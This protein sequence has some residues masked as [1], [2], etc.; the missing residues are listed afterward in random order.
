KGARPGRGASKIVLLVGAGTVLALIVA[1]GVGAKF[2]TPYGLFGQY[3]FERFLP[4]AG[5]PQQIEEALKKSRELYVLDTIREGRNALKLL[6]EARNVAGVNRRLLVESAAYEALYRQRFGDKK[7]GTD[8]RLPVMMQRIEERAGD[9]PHLE[10]ARAAEALARGEKDQ[11]QKAAKLA[12][13]GTL[14]G[15]LIQGEAQLALGQRK[16][17]RDAFI[18]ARGKGGKASAEWGIARTW[19]GTGNREE[20]E[21]AIET[22][23]KL[24]PY[25]S[26]ARVEKARLLM[27]EQ[28][29]EAISLLHEVL[30]RKKVGKLFLRSSGTAKSDA[31]TLLGLYHQS[32]RDHAT[33]R[34]AFLKAHETDGYN[35]EAYVYGGRLHMLDSNYEEAL[36]R[37]ETVTGGGEPRPAKQHSDRP[38]LVQ[39]RLGQVQALLKLR[40]E[41]EALAIVSEL[42]KNRAEDPL[43][44]L[45]LGKAE[46]AADD[47][48]GAEQHYRETMRLAPNEFLGYNALAQLFF[49]KGEPEQAG[50]VLKVASERVGET[51]EV[52]R[53]LG[54]SDL[55]RSDLPA[56]VASFRRAL[57][58]DPKDAQ[59]KFLLGVALRRSGDLE[60]AA[61][62]LDEVAQLSPSHV[63]L[64]VERGRVFEQQG[65]PDAAVAMYTKAL[66]EDGDDIDLRLR[67][68]AAQ[69]LAGDI[70][71]AEANLVAVIAVRPRSA[72][73]EHFL[74]R[75]AFAREDYPGA[76]ARF[77]QAVELDP[78]QGLFHAYYGWI[79]LERGNFSVAGQALDRAIRLDPTLA[80]AY[81]IRGRLRL[82]TG[83]A[84][85]SLKDLAKAVELNPKLADAYALMGQAYEQ[86]KRRTDALRAYKQAVELKPNAGDWW[87]ALAILQRNTEKRAEAMH[88]FAK[89]VEIGEGMDPKPRWLADA[90]R[91]RAD[92]AMLG[93]ETALARQGFLRFLELV[94]KD[95]ADRES[96]R[97]TLS[98]E[99]GVELADE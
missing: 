9:V 75:V 20:I 94:P 2:F 22:T 54:E 24:S 56:A 52:Y 59:A 7:F 69:V 97:R 91:E 35:A 6:S 58:L 60:G 87:L 13:A 51:P 49:K 78:E 70:S 33:A 68:G 95:D 8:S 99:L 39:A 32:E 77:K 74:G 41:E 47:P 10:V 57:E 90:H 46:E 11:Y 76:S 80:T 26:G 64:A 31:Y 62:A 53:T 19:I 34:D 98:L 71:G 50:E 89:A 48:V 82:R 15:A 18:A 83:A 16:A 72:E 55:A 93:R 36:A 1:A 79:E 30:A 12:S 44:M 4:G 28:P 61:K 63:G 38:I 3:A 88:S 23:L 14:L 85:D 25:H 73:A 66:E 40:R 86:R 81:W 21:K 27:D 17:A 92:A 65:D 96:V 84:K 29:G 43:V 5:S 67:L 37:F 42:A 45:W